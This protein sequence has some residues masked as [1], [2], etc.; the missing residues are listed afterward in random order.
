M[1]KH[2]VESVNAFV[3]EKH[4]GMCTEIY[5]VKPGKKTIR[6]GKF[7]CKKEHT[8]DANI[9]DVISG[10]S[11]W[12]VL[13]TK[14]NKLLSVQEEANDYASSRNGK[15]LSIYTGITHKMTWECEVG[16]QWKTAY[17]GMKQN[18]SWC[19]ACNADKLRLSQED[20][21]SHIKSKGGKCLSQY[22]G[23][24]CLLL[25]E[26]E[27][28]HQWNT[29]FSSI[30]SGG[31]WCPTCAIDNRRLD[32]NIVNILAAEKGGKCLTVYTT[33]EDKMT[34]ECAKGHTWEASVH[35]VKDIGSWCPTCANNARRLSEDEPNIYAKIKGGKCLTMYTSIN[36]KL[37]WECEI[38]HQWEATFNAIKH[39]G[40]W[41]PTCTTPYGKR[42]AIIVHEHAAMRNG[43]CLTEYISSNQKLLWECELKHQ[44]EATFTRVIGENTW[45]PECRYKSETECRKILERLF[46]NPFIKVRPEWIKNIDG[47]CL[48]LDGYCE[49]LKL[50]FEYNGI[51]HYEVADWWGLTHD[52]LK[53]QQEHDRIKAEACADRGIGLIVIPYTMKKYEDKVAFIRQWLA[54]STVK[55]PTVE[56]AIVGE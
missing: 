56:D 54:S 48:E 25:V 31:K 2:T 5:V 39:G 23:Y 45:C 13:C 36:E 16:H 20:V 30:K 33:T 27:R 37:L 34:W 26:C 38:G 14:L 22:V 28:G 32:P 50:A 43:K 8:W 40:S 6:M 35:C 1:V 53:K 12:C 51:Q 11:L 7:V 17:K 9:S 52:D 46:I 21:H 55:Y 24:N 29:S 19:S 42:H 49:E 15:C 3:H 10:R 44:W 47:N 41:C 4:G 18:N